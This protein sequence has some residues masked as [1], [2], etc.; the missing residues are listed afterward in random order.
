MAEQ[1]NTPETDVTDLVEEATFDY[2]MGDNDAALA[3]LRQAVETNP[4]SFAGWHA[5]TEVH[6]SLGHFREALDAAEHAYRIDSGDIHINTSL[7]RI[8]MELGDKPTA[9][10]FG[11]QARMLGWKQQL[12]EPDDEN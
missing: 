11:A 7:S 2:T 3:K 8:H 1:A 12:Q 4:N 9:E 10:H 5:L 6:F